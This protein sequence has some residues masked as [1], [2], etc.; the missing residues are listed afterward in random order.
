MRVQCDFPIHGCGPINF[1][2]ENY[3]TIEENEN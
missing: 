1:D 2:K 3:T